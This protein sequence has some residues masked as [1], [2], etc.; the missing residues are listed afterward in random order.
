MDD[1]VSVHSDKSYNR[2]NCVLIG[3]K[4]VP[5]S[6]RCNNSELEN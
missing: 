4:S 5:K 6:V 1:N 2:Q 3:L